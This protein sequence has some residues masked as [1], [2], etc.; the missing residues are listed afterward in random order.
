MF[1]KISKW[2]NGKPSSRN[3]DSSESELDTTCAALSEPSCVAQAKT[4]TAPTSEFAIRY[5]R[6]KGSVPRL[7]AIGRELFVSDVKA[8]VKLDTMAVIIHCARHETVAVYEDPN[9]GIRWLPFTPTCPGKTWTESATLGTLLILS[10]TEEQYISLKQSPPFKSVQLLENLRIQLPQTLNILTRMIFYVRLTP[11]DSFACCGSGNS[12]AWISTKELAEGAVTQ[13]W[14]PELVQYMRIV[15]NNFEDYMERI[16]EFSLDDVYMYSPREPPR[17]AEET[18]LLE[19]GIS[20]KTIEILYNDFLD[21]C[22]PCFSLPIYSFKQYMS[23]Y[24][25]RPDDERLDSLFIAFN[26]KKNG[27]VS[28]HEL[29]MGLVALEPQASHQETRIKFIFRF[30][31]N[32][33]KG[34]LS[35]ENFAKLVSDMNPSLEG[36][37]LQAKLEECSEAVEFAMKDGQRCVTFA[38]L[39]EAIASL[40]LRGSSRLC[41]SNVP[42]FLQITM[43]YI[44]RRKPTTE[45]LREWKDLKS[46]LISRSFKGT[47]KGCRHRKFKLATHVITIEANGYPSNPV[48]IVSKENKAAP[49]DRNSVDLV[50]NPKSIC[51][52]IL[53]LV[54]QFAKHKGAVRA[55]RGLLD[56]SRGPEM[57]DLLVRLAKEVKPILKA[58]SRCPNV[59]SPGQSNILIE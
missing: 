37:E 56:G 10:T 23:R 13:I 50:F 45:D 20:E 11:M 18:M 16:E 55:P 19:L 40:R 49:T 22:F 58:E 5:N 54:R 31:D 32:N 2:F 26:Y 43:A 47:C 30:Y 4:D 9:S 1:D 42:V 35:L 7:S 48:R 51:N 24:G 12:I 6:N 52:V 8:D 57:Y 15:N 29:L 14:G 17:N 21:H 25:F 39:M 33:S 46:V 44:R 41:R 28:F 34:Y 38:K 59:C 36:N 53:N 27:Y 3:S